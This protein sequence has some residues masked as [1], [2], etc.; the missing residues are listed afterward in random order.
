[1]NS[2]RRCGRSLSSKEESSSTGAADTTRSR[3]KLSLGAGTGAIVP[4]PENE[5]PVRFSVLKQSAAILLA[6]E[7]GRVET[8]SFVVAVR[9]GTPR[10]V[11]MSVRNGLVFSGT[12]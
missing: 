1:M 3:F 12:E 2:T 5:S 10:D 8:L 11:G 9:F 4:V 7:H 6:A